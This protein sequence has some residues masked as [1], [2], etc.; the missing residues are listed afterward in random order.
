MTEEQPPCCELEE[1]RAVLL[2]ALLNSETRPAHQG[3]HQLHSSPPP[4]PLSLLISI[5]LWTKD[6]GS[7]KEKKTA[8]QKDRNLKME[9]KTKDNS[10]K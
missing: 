3:A 9:E 2:E 4:G 8:K 10:K 7:P 1:D 6:K 5:Q